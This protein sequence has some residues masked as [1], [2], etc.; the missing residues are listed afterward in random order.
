MVVY[1]A[2]ERLSI[3]VKGDQQPF[4]C[5]VV[6]IFHYKTHCTT[7]N[8]KNQE[9][10]LIIIYNLILYSKAHLYKD[11]TLIYAPN[12]S[13][14]D[15]DISNNTANKLAQG[16]RTAF[17]INFLVIIHPKAAPII[18]ISIIPK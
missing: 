13:L 18:K 1:L 16:K 11:K 12:F 17:I 4:H 2:L 7:F 8:Y 5:V 10:C 14:L 9:K 3:E 15:K 6:S